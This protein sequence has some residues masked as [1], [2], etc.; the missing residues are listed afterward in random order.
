M[1]TPT[2]EARFI[3]TASLTDEQPKHFRTLPTTYLNRAVTLSASGQ[4]SEMGFYTLHNKIQEFGQTHIINLRQEHHFFVNKSAITYYHGEENDANKGLSKDEILSQLRP[5]IDQ[6]HTAGS[7]QIATGRQKQKIQ[8]VKVTTFEKTVPMTVQE[9]SSEDEVLEKLE[10]PYT[11]F[12]ITDH[13]MKAL[14]E[15]IDALIQTVLSRLATG[16]KWIHFHCQGGKARSAMAMLLSAIL[17]E[18]KTKSLKEIERIFTLNQDFHFEARKYKKFTVFF[19]HYYTYCKENNPQE[20]SWSAWA[21]KKGVYESALEVLPEN[22]QDK[23][24]VK[25][26]RKNRATLH[27]A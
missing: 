27:K 20:I 9:T 3:I 10:I 18:A 6:I 11:F 14:G 22:R 24:R 17:L 25:E 4:P 23:A 15:R 2:P 19:E 16:T 26:L 7:I 13:N 21:K 1:T 5:L 12:P 8:G